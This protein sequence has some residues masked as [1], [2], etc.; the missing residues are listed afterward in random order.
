M[1]TASTF[2]NSSDY[3]TVHMHYVSVLYMGIYTVC[4]MEHPCNQNTLL[5]PKGVCI[6]GAPLYSYFCH[7]SVADML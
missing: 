7:N 5:V 4:E 3:D 1:Q 2:M 6:I